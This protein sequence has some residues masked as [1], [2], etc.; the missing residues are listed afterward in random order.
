MIGSSVRSNVSRKRVCSRSRT[1]VLVDAGV[2][3]VRLAVPEDR[4]MG[5]AAEPAVGGLGLGADPGG[6]LGLLPL[7]LGRDS[8]S[9]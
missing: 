4:V 3:D 6:L 5:Q 2:E 8:R 7:G 9:G 1:E